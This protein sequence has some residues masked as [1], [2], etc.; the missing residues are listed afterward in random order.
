METHMTSTYTTCEHGSEIRAKSQ[1]GHSLRQTAVRLARAVRA[2]GIWH[3]IRILERQARRRAPGPAL[4][5]LAIR[6]AGIVARVANAITQEL[7]IR[8]DTRELML[9]SDDMLKDIGIT[10]A[11]IASIVRYGREG[12]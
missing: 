6:L 2:Y 7:Q 10:R 1:V 8:R 12:R 5:A 3:D 9:M 4:A 11:E